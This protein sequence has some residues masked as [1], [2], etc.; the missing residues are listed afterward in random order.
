ML[1]QPTVNTMRYLI[2]QS[3]KKNIIISVK[4]VVLLYYF[5]II[6][7]LNKNN[8]IIEINQLVNLRVTIIEYLYFLKIEILPVYVS[9]VV[10]I[11]ISLQII[12]Y[13]MLSDEFTKQ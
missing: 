3:P 1:K 4:T 10:L 8:R 7:K 5:I 11:C 2:R 6:N 13:V 12:A 9:A